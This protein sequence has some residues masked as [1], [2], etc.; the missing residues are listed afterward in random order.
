MRQAAIREKIA[1]EQGL[2]FTV[3]NARE[4]AAKLNA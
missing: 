2:D 3:E 4:L 1:K